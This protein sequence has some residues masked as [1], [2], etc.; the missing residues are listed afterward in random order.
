MNIGFVLLSSYIVLPISNFLSWRMAIRRSKRTRFSSPPDS[1]MLR[2]MTFNYRLLM[3]LVHWSRFYT[4]NVNQ[5]QEYF[6]IEGS[7]PDLCNGCCLHSLLYI[8]MVRARQMLNMMDYI[9][10]KRKDIV[11][12]HLY[13]YM[14]ILSTK[15]FTMI[16]AALTCPEGII[17]I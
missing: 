12:S 1:L 6:F 13:F 17:D 2:I 11:N 10:Q 15:C 14:S 9:E 7:G 4:I 16:I 8:M 5:A 3:N